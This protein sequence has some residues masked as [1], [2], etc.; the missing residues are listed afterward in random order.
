MLMYLAHMP[1]IL[2][3]DP[4]VVEAL[5][6]TRNAFLTKQY[7]IKSFQINLLG[8]SIL[9]EETNENWRQRRKVL[10]PAFYKDKLRGL[11]NLASQA[12]KKSI[13]NMNVDQEQTIEIMGE[14]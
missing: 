10:T 7:Y 14:I 3:C 9:F 11:V 12:V 8:N 2:I 6:T 5:Y 1:R 13:K 4:K